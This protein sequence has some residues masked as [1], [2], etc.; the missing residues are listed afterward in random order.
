MLV[1]A[2]LIVSN[3]SRFSAAELRSIATG[4]TAGATV[5]FQ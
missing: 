2:T 3:A 1:G 5:L 4:S